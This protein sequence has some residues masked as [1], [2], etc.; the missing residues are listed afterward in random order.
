MLVLIND[1][2]IEIA[3]SGHEQSARY[4]AYHDSIVKVGE[5]GPKTSKGE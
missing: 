4:C 3:E 1:R 2:V 5:A